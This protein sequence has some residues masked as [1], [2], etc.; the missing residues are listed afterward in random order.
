MKLLILGAGGHGRVVKEVAE[1]SGRYEDIVFL[2][3]TAYGKNPLV[4]GTLN[5]AKMFIEDFSESFVALG[6]PALRE[7]WQCL[8]GDYGF[9]IPTLIHAQA[10]ISPSASIGRGSIIM[11]GAIVQSGCQ[12]KEGVI[13][14]ANAVI[15]HDSRVEA[16]CHIN[17]AGIVTSGSFVPKKTKVDYGQVFR[18]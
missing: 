15:D 4:I 2:D 13:V 1:M 17:V 12:I 7:Y 3:D 10:Y 6:N 18:T 16:Y 11:A 8:L 9:S 5:Q 14:S